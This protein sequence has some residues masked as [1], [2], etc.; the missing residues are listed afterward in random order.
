M[1]TVLGASGNTGGRVVAQLRAAGERVRAVGR[2]ADRLAAAVGR[3]AEPFVADA[4]DADV[5]RTAFDGAKAAYV[6]MPTDITAAGYASSQAA[7]GTAIVRALAAAGV[8]RVVALSS[9]GAEV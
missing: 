5:L 6:L 8:P 2:D 3:G 1:I 7:V 9:L 4:R